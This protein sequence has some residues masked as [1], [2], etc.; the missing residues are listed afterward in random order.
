MIRD[1]FPN[2][3]IPVSQFDPVAVKVQNLI[4]RATNGNLPTSNFIGP[5]R[6]DR[7]TTIPSFK[8]DQSL[9]SRS[10]ISF[11]FSDTVTGSQYSP[12]L[13]ASDGLPVPITA[14]IG[15]FDVARTYR[16]NFEQTLT[17]RLLLHL[18]VGFQDNT[19]NDNAP[20]LDYDA[21]RDLGLKGATVKRMFP[22][23]TGLSNAQGGVKN[24]GPGTNRNLFYAKPTANASVTWVKSNHTYKFGAEMKIEGSPGILYAGTNGAYAFSADQTSLPSTQGQNLSGGV[25]GSPYASFLL[26]AVSSGSIS[27]PV[28]L[29]A[30]KSQWGGFAQDTWKI[31]RKLTLDYGLRY[32]FSTYL[33]EQYG[34]F[35]NFS[36]TTPNPT[37]G[38]QPGAVN[39][40]GYGP[41]HCNCDLAKNYPW[42]FGPR[43]GMAFQIN[44]KTVFRAGWGLV[45]SGTADANA[46]NQ[47]AS[48]STPFTSSAFAQPAMLLRNGIPITPRPWPNFDPGQYP[49]AGQINSPQVAIDQNSGRPARQNQWSVGLQREIFRDLVVEA[50]YV[51]NRGVWWTAPGLIDVNAGRPEIL[52]K[53]GLNLNN[54]DDRALLN[55]RLDSPMALARGFNKPPYTGF[56]TSLTVAQAL[57]PFPQFGTITYF[58]S[59]LGKTWYDSLQAKATQRFSHGLSLTSVFTWQKNLTLG[60]DRNPTAGSTGNASFNDVF[61]RDQNKYFSSF[62]QTY[63]FNISG[64]YTVP[65]FKIGSGF[66]GS[67]AS[68]AVRDWTITSLVAY[69][70]G[71]P[72]KAPAGPKSACQPVV[73]LHLR[74][75]RAGAATFYAGPELP[76]LRSQQDLRPESQGVG[77]PR[78]RPIRHFGGFLWGLPIP[79]ASG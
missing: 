20:V 45:Y 40:D 52:A 46:V 5:Y 43:L 63:V 4:P 3:T 15:T 32:D 59:P 6:S 61:N 10:K 74:K 31:T 49:L 56:P 2:N 70:T 12:T 8:I 73:P 21:E 42:A 67:A 35:A 34:R 64:T 50:A 71:L 14:A 51:A 69:A 60:N 24:L 55:S 66:A 72:I 30:G 16:L 22:A 57:R 39:F 38:G 28:V 27:Y 36:P 53:Y 58:W 37:A 77:G 26:G 75:S 18:G 13:G 79:A 41:G 62:D 19:F 76:L 68:W 29:R 47:Q 44:S 23:F 33:R 7:V 25:V 48:G 9:G 65:K 1:Q 54:A 78:S 11:Y 17:P